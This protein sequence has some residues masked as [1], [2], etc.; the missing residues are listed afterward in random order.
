MIIFNDHTWQTSSNYPNTNYLRGVEGVTQ[1]QWVVPDNTELA[2][3]IISTFYWEPVE[4][5]KGNLIDITPVD[6][7]VTDKERILSLKNQLEELDR[8]AIRPLRAI[9]AGTDT[10]EDREILTNLERQ[11][12]ELRSQ[13]DEL[14]SNTGEEEN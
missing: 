6:P 10:E 9:A 14:E 5:D 4:D 12:E 11:A 1:P 8:Q 3:K 7:P 2:N 13:I